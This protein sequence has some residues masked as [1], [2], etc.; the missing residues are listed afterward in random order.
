[1]GT[2]SKKKLVAKHMELEV[3]TTRTVTGRECSRAGGGYCKTE[4][5]SKI[6]KLPTFF[7]GILA[8]VS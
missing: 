6:Y 3:K 1:M 7:I 4:N 5:L 8:D 2:G